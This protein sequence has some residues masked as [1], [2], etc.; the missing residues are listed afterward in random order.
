MSGPVNL[1][2]NQVLEHLPV[3]FCSCDTEGN[4]TESNRH[5]TDLW[6]SKPAASARF[7][8]AARLFDARGKL[9]PQD[10]SPIACALR[11]RKPQRNMELIV[12]R[13]DG[14]RITVLSNAAPLLDADSKLLGAL[15][16]FHDI[17]ERRYVEEARRVADRLAASARVANQVAQ[18][19]K[20]PLVSLTSLLDILR[21]ETNLSAE[22]RSYTELIEQELSRFDRLAQEMVHLSI[23]A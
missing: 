5:A 15:E 13:P 14:R 6:G 3:A 8:G 4:V 21:K 9:L 7:H 16:V 17:T 22:A 11:T 18:Q 19:I 12:E 23:A 10:Q 1:F 20:K 2:Q